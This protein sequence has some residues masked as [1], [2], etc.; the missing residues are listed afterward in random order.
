MTASPE[1]RALW[2][3][4]RSLATLPERIAKRQ[5]EGLAT[6]LQ[7]AELEHLPF[8]IS[9]LTYIVELQQYEQSQKQV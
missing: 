8:A 4:K 3:F 2:H 6:R 5:A 7:E 9:A 1:E